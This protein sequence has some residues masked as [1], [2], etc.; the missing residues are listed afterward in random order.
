[1]CAVNFFPLLL[2]V[3]ATVLLRFEAVSSEV[4]CLPVVGKPNGSMESANLRVEIWQKRSRN[5][6]VLTFFSVAVDCQLCSG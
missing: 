6:Q 1:M 2:V 5:L 3:V 4:T